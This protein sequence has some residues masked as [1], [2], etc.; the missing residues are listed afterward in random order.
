MPPHAPCGASAWTAASETRALMRCRA[1][2]AAGLGAPA[3]ARHWCARTGWTATSWWRCRGVLLSWR[4]C[5]VRSRAWTCGLCVHNVQPWRVCLRAH[6]YGHAGTP[7]NAAPHPHRAVPGPQPPDKPARGACHHD[8][9]VQAVSGLRTQGACSAGYVCSA[10]CAQQQQPTGHCCLHAPARRGSHSARARARAQLRGRQPCAR[11]P[12]EREAASVLS[13]GRCTVRLLAT[14]TW[15]VAGDVRD[16]R[17]GLHARGTT[18]VRA[19]VASSRCR[20]PTTTRA[21]RPSRHSKGRRTRRD[22]AGLHSSARGVAFSGTTR[23]RG[24]TYVYLQLLNR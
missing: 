10:A 21:P 4:P 8:P 2:V 7:A 20:R 23:K 1:L 19:C 18:A 13:G 22:R 9:A 6:A 16:K 5:K 3:Q 15:G 17:A 11:H 24:R 12:G 14:C